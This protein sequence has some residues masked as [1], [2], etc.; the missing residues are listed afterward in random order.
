M[1]LVAVV[2]Q[3]ISLFLPYNVK[4]DTWD[5]TF[6]KTYDSGFDIILPPIALALFIVLTTLFFIKHSLVTKII[7]VL[8]TAFL[9]FPGSLYVYF[10]TIFCFCQSRLNFGFYLYAVAMLLIIFAAILKTITR[11]QNKNKPDAE[12][13]DSSF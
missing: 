1:M 13:L 6:E 5:Q 9:I 7:A 2:L 3:A 10:V 12:L 4:I 11:L 8:L